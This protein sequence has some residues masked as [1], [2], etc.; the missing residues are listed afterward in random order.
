LG[1]NRVGDLGRGASRFTRRIAKTAGVPELDAGRG[2]GERAENVRHGATWCR[3]DWQIQ[4]GALDKKSPTGIF[5]QH[6]KR[7]EK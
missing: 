4:T 1:L 5:R 7:T 2:V 6:T 3:D